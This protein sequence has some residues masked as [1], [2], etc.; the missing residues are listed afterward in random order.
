MLIIVYNLAYIINTWEAN[1][2]N[3]VKAM[4]FKVG[5]ERLKGRIRGGDPAVRFIETCFQRI[6][7]SQEYFPTGATSLLQI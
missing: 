2:V 4:V 6:F 1:Q 5:D 7:S 3:N